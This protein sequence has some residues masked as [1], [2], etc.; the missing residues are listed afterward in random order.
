LVESIK[1][2]KDKLNELKKFKDFTNDILKFEIKMTENEYKYIKFLNNL[3]LF[4]ISPDNG[5]SQDLDKMP[6]V[7]YLKNP[8]RTYSEPSGKMPAKKVA[9][10]ELNRGG[11]K[12]KTKR[13]T[14]RTIKHSKSKTKRSGRK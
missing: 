11:S 9:V 14:R 3:I 6:D 4:S 8:S 7:K 1:R 5:G 2:N 10:A 12:K 13:L